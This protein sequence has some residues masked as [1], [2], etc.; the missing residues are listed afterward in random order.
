[1]AR[2][3]IRSVTAAAII[4][5]TVTN[6]KDDDGGRLTGLKADP[7][8]HFRAGA[9][10]SDTVDASPLQA[11]VVEVRGEDGQPAVGHTVR[12]TSVPNPGASPF[13]PYR[14]YVS[15]VELNS[16]SNLAADVTNERGQASVILRF[17]TSAGPGRV[18]V[19][20]PD[21]GMTDTTTFTVSA[22]AASRVVAAPKDTALFAGGTVTM[23]SAVT[24]RYGNPRN[25]PV[26]I[27]RASGGVTV[28]GK[29]VSA[30]TTGIAKVVTAALGITDTTTIAVVPSGVVLAASAPGTGVVTLNLDGSGYRVVTS[31]PSMWVRWA[32]DG[33]E[34]TFDND[35][36]LRG[37]CDR[38]LIL[39]RVAVLESGC[40]DLTCS[41]TPA[42]YVAP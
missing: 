27:T 15:P 26:T 7:G 11:L 6:C 35:L 24:D 40:A 16:F 33:T 4:I 3:R 28:A 39:D 41:A 2:V 38:N 19:S 5:A 25:D 8:I 21:L 30:Q 12:F 31:T 32:P 17:G 9:T 20:V 42:L 34:L 36:W 14:V 29:V 13:A 18:A 10:T 22:G 23:R 1:M 37:Q